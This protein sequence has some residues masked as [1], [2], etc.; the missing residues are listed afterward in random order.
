MATYIV[1]SDRLT[2]YTRGDI[3]KDTDLGSLAYDLQFLLESGHLSTHK[4]IKPAKTK[5][6]ETEE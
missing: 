2:G 3:I 6:I 1:T 4:V 5:L